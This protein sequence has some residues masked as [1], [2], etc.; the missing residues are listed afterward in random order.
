MFSFVN[1]MK[2]TKT[3]CITVRANHGYASAADL[4][5]CVSPK[6]KSVYEINVYYA[7][8]SSGLFLVGT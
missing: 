5:R 3:K 8:M 2:L 6:H 1:S 7:E 4:W